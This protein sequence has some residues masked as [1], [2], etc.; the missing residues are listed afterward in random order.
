M[1]HH[2][3]SGAV[4]ARGSVVIVEKWQLWS[5]GGCEAVVAVEQWWLRSEQCWL[6]SSGGCG[7]VVA[8]EA[9][10]AVEQW[11]LQ[12]SGGGSCGAMVA[13]VEQCWLTMEQ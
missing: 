4:A 9:V 10:V 8:C 7:A 1:S 13:H 2:R 12:W 5:S 6:R 3:S 11:W